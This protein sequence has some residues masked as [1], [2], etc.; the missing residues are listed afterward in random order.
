MTQRERD[1]IGQ[2]MGRRAFLVTLPLLGGAA[3]L[4]A[5]TPAPELIP[6]QKNP[7]N[8]E[9][10]FASLNSFITP[11]HLHYVR[12]HY[13]QPD[14]D[15]AGWRLRIIGAVDNSLNLSYADLR[16]MPARSATVTMECAGNGRSFLKPKSKGVQWDMGAVSTAEWTGVP[17]AALLDRAGV[18]SNAVEVILEGADQGDPQKDAAPPGN[19]AFARSLPLAKARRAEV[20][21]AYRMNGVDLPKAHGFPVRA[22]VGGWYGMASVKWLTRIIVTDKP[23]FGFDQTI[24][25]AVWEQRDGLPTL[26]AIT[27]M[28]PKALIARPT[29]GEKIAAGNAYRIH[30]AAWAGEQEIDR[31]EVSTNGGRSWSA[32]TLLAEAIPLAWR[33]WEYPWRPAAQGQHIL[34]ARAYDKSGRAQPLERDPGR[35]NYRISHVLS[36]AVDV[37]A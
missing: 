9:F 28:D 14:L 26:T 29:A 16:A 33:L 21:L 27:A 17:L 15:A 34:M 30:G 24:D 36:T 37:G 18:K 11:N 22:I 23:F 1:G 13:P 7:D 25:Y 31:V 10:P 4:F 6:R 32:A 12:N 2:S 8:L 19:V 3:S 35:R 20:L 5:D